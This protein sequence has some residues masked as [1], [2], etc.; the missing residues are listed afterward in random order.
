MTYTEKRIEK[1]RQLNKAIRFTSDEE[2]PGI[3]DFLSKSI[4]GALAEERERVVG[5]WEAEFNSRFIDVFDGNAYIYAPGNVNDITN[6]IRD[7]LTAKDREIE[8]AGQVA[9]KRYQE[10]IQEEL[11]QELTKAKIEAIAE[12]RE[13]VRG[14][15]EEIRGMREESNEA[16]DYLQDRIEKGLLS[17]LNKSYKK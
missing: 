1:L 3:E 17:S 7:L 16:L 15:I 8:E 12:E 4:Q 5:N 14:L 13:R 6:F 11:E 10:L 2:L 9:I